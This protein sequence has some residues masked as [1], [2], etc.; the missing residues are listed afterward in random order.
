MDAERNIITMDEYGRI[1][2]S[3]A[4]AKNIWMSTKQTNS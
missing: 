1:H 3:D 4:T 2:F